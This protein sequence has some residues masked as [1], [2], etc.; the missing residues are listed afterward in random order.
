MSVTPHVSPKLKD[1][2]VVGEVRLGKFRSNLLGKAPQCAH[3]D[4]VKHDAAGRHG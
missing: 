1:L 2:N 4:S 3:Q